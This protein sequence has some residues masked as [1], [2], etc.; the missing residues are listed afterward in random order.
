[1]A[2]AADPPELEA[3][4]VSRLVAARHPVRAEA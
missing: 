3:K 4:R 2:A 1:L